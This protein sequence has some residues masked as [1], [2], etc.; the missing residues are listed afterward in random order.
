MNN[1]KKM[2]LL[3]LSP[4]GWFT[5]GIWPIIMASLMLF[6]K[7]F[8]F[9]KRLFVVL[10]AVIGISS[11]VFFIIWGIYSITMFSMLAGSIPLLI[12]APFLWFTG[13]YDGLSDTLNTELIKY[14]IWGTVFAGC[15][16]ILEAIAITFACFITPVPEEIIKVEQPYETSETIIIE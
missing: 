6:K 9:E 11:Y 3:S 2:Y 15:G 16:V 5:L 7:E 12:F 10:S 1:T 4:V 13:I 8:R 14:V